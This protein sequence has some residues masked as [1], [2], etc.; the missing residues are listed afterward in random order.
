TRQRT[1]QVA[2]RAQQVL[3]HG[4]YP[5]EIGR[6]LGGPG[7][8]LVGLP[9]TPV[10]EIQALLVFVR[11]RRSVGGDDP[12]N[13]RRL[14]IRQWCRPRSGVVERHAHAENLP[15]PTDETAA[16]ANF[17]TAAPE[18]PAPGLGRPSTTIH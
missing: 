14:G 13:S 16:L 3:E 7:D 2:Q 9:R 8:D 18:P 1:A 6:Q 10:V 4:H 12:L 5:L 17:P 11:E 15:T